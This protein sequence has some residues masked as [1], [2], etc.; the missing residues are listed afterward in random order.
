MSIPNQE[1][2][3]LE[4][5][6]TQFSSSLDCFRELVQNALDAGSPSVDVWME[7][8]RGQDHHGVI[9]IHVDDYGEGMDEAIIENQLTKLFSSTKE[10]DLTKIGKFGIGFVSVFAMNPKGVL[11]KTGRGGQY[12]EVFFYPDRSFAKTPIDEPCEGTQ[13]TLFIEGDYRRYRELVDGV[14][15]TLKR[16]CAHADHEITFEDRSPQGDAWSQ[17]ELINEPFDVPGVC[18]CAVSH[19]G[20]E[21]LVAYTHTPLYGLYNRGLTL[22]LERVGENILDHR[23]ARYRHISFKIKSRYLEHTLSR[24]TVVR[25]A[26]YEKA[27]SLV[28]DAVNG[29]LLNLLC[30]TLEELVATPSWGHE[31]VVAYLHLLSFLVQEPSSSLVELGERKLLRL[32]DGSSASLSQL[33]ELYATQGRLLV[34]DHRSELVQALAAAGTPVLFGHPPTTHV[35]ATSTAALW[36]PTRLFVRFAGLNA[37]RS[38]KGKARRLVGWAFNDKIN[39]E[40]EI[41]QALSA[42][43]A[44]YL[45]V[46]VDAK[47]PDELAALVQAAQSLLKAAQTPYRRLTTCTISSPG[48]D[49]PLFVVAPKLS[50][51]MSRPPKHMK[52]T[53]IMEAAINRDHHHVKLLL[54]MH[55]QQPRMAA[56]CMAKALLLVQDRQLEL[57][58]TL[59]SLARAL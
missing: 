25:D 33:Q 24:E 9:S 5:L 34:A 3:L 26:N 27:M 31:Q 51:L 37:K 15:A 58:Q 19:Q 42:P 35:V 30:S 32:L 21:I 39:F 36:N 22:A 53:R 49:I 29:P 48:E 56:Y 20:T 47:P 38:I 4:N 55:Q 59:M 17:P 54:R 12:W 2:G 43:E 46:T 16:W 41:I 28:D 18:K 6:V 45:P 44:V 7:F 57:D 8:E 11:V 23:A 14:K 10:N 13:I 50:T 40:S 1:V 52:D